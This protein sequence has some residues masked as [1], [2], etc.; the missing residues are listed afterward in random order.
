MYLRVRVKE[1]KEAEEDK[2]MKLLQEWIF[3]NELCMK[4]FIANGLSFLFYVLPH[5]QEPPPLSLCFISV[6][7]RTTFPIWNSTTH[8]KKYNFKL[9]K[10]IVA[11]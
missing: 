6:T 5:L 7:T 1:H 4:G 10:E 8:I 9:F 3:S 2:E 11:K